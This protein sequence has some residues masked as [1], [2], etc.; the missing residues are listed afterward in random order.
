MKKNDL[1]VDLD[2]LDSPAARRSNDM[3]TTTWISVAVNIALSA[4]QIVTGLVASSQGLIAD[5]VHS[6]SDLIADGVVLLANHESSKEADAEHPYGHHRFETAASLILGVLLLAT[7]IGIGWNAIGKLLHPET[8]QRVGLIALWVALGALTAK[9]CLFRVML[10]T[11]QRLQSSLLVANAWHARSDA[12]SSLV[13]GVG[14]VGN[15]AGYPILDPLAA[16]IVGLIIMKMGGEFAYQALNDLVDRAAE[17]TQVEAIRRSLLTIPGVL[18]VHDLRTRK[19]GDLI[20]VDAHIEVDGSITVRA[21][22]DITKIARLRLMENH[23]VISL[24]AHLDP[25]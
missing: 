24:M 5:G 15:L 20:A 10:R 3:A 4:A 25:V 8:I 7:G 23:R 17:E 9:E 16:V 22:H 1:A 12:A 13:V 19:M 14:I 2:A 6:L 11:A 18:G 21:G